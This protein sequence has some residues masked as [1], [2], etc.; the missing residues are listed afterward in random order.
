[1]EVASNSKQDRASNQNFEQLVKAADF[2]YDCENDPVDQQQS[3]NPFD[4]SWVN[5][6]TLQSVALRCRWRNCNDCFH[7][8]K[9][10]KTHMFSKHWQDLRQIFTNYGKVLN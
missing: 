4:T 9:L 5:Y 6:S 2:A 8:A 3:I 10:L 7:S 1:M